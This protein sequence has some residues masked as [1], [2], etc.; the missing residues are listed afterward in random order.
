MPGV[1]PEG[2]VGRQR[3]GGEHVEHGA[4]DAPLAHRGHEI[5]V[6]DEIA[7]AEVEQERARLHARQRASCS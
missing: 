2:V 3:L 1:R 7:A 4:G 5:G 6:D